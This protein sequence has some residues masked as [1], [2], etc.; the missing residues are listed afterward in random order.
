MQGRILGYDAVTFTGAITGHDGLRYDFTRADWRDG[1][2][3]AVG[4]QVDFVQAGER[5]HDV[6]LLAQQRPPFTW[7]WFLLS[8]DGRISRK[9]FWLKYQLPLM[10]LYCAVG[11]L[12]ILTADTD[13]AV[14]NGVGSGLS[15]VAGVLLVLLTLLSLWPGIAVQVKRC[16]DRNRSGWFLLISLIPIVGNLWLLAELGF[17]RGTSGDNRFGGDPLA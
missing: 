4:M 13:A 2:E 12:G 9:E 11:Y 7:A 8:L 14:G 16:H 15:P 5:A 1:R 3:P 6:Y 17:I 10:V